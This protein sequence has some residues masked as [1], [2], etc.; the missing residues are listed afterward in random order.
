MRLTAFNVKQQ[1]QTNVWLVGLLLV[2]AMIAG[3]ATWQAIQKDFE[4]LEGNRYRWSEFSDKWVVVNYFAEWCAPCLREIPELVAFNTTKPADTAIF[5]I[6]YDPLSKVRIRELKDKYQIN[7]PL[8]LP[9]DEMNM[10]MERPPYLPATF[11]IGPDGKVKKTLMG[12][13]SEKLLTD[14]ISALK[15]QPL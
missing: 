2:G 1:G 6:S 15:S 14:T 4:T 10:P 7:L 5:A 12:E 9:D 13:V 8:V 3:I 11:I